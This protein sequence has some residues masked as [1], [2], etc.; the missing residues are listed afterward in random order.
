MLRMLDMSGQ[1][2]P[3]KYVVLAVH[4]ENVEY[5]EYDLVVF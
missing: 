5:A 1:Q 3:L 2:S 4:T